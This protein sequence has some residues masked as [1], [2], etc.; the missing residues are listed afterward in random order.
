MP[1]AR[2]TAASLS[3]AERLDAL[4]ELRTTVRF[5]LD[6]ALTL[7][8]E[9]GA[10]E[11]TVGARLSRQDAAAFKRQLALLDDLE[12][13]LRDERGRAAERAAARREDLYSLESSAKETA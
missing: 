12:A 7:A 4:S 5:Q 2:S 13:W 6:D 11:D 1:R 8:R 9:A 10:T 3:L